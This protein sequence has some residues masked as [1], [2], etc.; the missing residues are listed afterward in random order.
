MKFERMLANIMRFYK[1][2]GYRDIAAINPIGKYLL[3]RFRSRRRKRIMENI[4][5]TKYF[6]TR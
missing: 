4:K 6:H 1:R 2:Q 3:Q 5:L